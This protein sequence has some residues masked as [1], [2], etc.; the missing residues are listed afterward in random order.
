[1]SRPGVVWIVT[2]IGCIAIHSRVEN[3]GLREEMVEAG[4]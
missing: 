4:P 2:L 1:V 3:L